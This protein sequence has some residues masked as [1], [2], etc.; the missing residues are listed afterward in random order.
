MRVSVEMWGLDSVKR[1]KAK[2]NPKPQYQ[3]SLVWAPHKKQLLIDSILRGYDLPKFYLRRSSEEGYD[4]EVVDG[5]QRLNAI[6]E[7][8]HDNISLP[9]ESADLPH[10]DVAGKKCS[11]LAHELQDVLY[12]Y[13]ISV[14]RIEESTEL[15]VRDLFLRLQDG[16]SLNPAERRNAMPGQMRN[17]IAE[18]AETHRV[19]PLTHY[20]SSRFG[21]HDLAA[22][23]TSLELAG[24][25]TDLKAANLKKMYEGNCDFDANGS[26]A[27]QIKRILGIFAKVIKDRPPE[28]D[29][30]WGFVD[31]YL[32]ISRLDSDY[33]VASYESH[34]LTFYVSFENERR[35][36]TDAA[37]LLIDR[38][39]WD[40]DLYEYIQAFTTSG[41][42]RSNIEKRHEV[43]YRRA[44]RDIPEMA[45]KDSRRAFLRD[46]RVVLWRLADGK[47]AICGEL[48][49]FDKYEA[50]HIVQYSQG[51]KTMIENG[52]VLCVAC[53]DKKHR[54]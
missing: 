6:W 28:M 29:I 12:G 5:Q 17:F 9:E 48:V 14:V 7:F 35:Q 22:H 31:L 13:Q 8:L 30:K 44:L 24:G 45:P 43:Y 27:K 46:E 52:Q 32:L 18:L 41:A 25:P 54:T 34:I 11:E 10:G 38:D 50:D 26:K 33:V 37:E 16:V 19:F 2:I 53:H 51:G 1:R 21:W 4:Y 47:C 15:E 40:K 39:P 23:V 36:T 3:Q 20:N 49:A 42:L